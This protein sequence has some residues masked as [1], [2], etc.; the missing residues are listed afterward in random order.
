MF[1]DIVDGIAAALTGDDMS[2]LFGGGDRSFFFFSS[3]RR[4]TRCSRDWSSDVCSSDLFYDRVIICVECGYAADAQHRAGHSGYRRDI[5]GTH[6]SYPSYLFVGRKSG[7]GQQ[8]NQRSLAIAT[9][10]TFADWLGAIVGFISKGRHFP[11]GWERKDI[12][13]P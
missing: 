10:K 13:P 1:G 4:H 8:L 11:Q 2:K 6:L 9:K 5:R 3:R 12:F 7:G